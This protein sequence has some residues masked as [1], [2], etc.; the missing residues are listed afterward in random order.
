MEDEIL[1]KESKEYK[2]LKKRLNP[3]KKGYSMGHTVIVG[4][5]SW[6]RE[7]FKKHESHDKW[8]KDRYI[9]GKWPEGE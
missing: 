2:E 8:F 4:Q 9:L 6:V 5:S 3:L 7:Q 1:I